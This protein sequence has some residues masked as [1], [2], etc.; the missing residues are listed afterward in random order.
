MVLACPKCDWRPQSY[1]QWTCTCGHRWHIFATD[2]VCPACGREWTSVR[3]F[4]YLGCGAWSDLLDWQH[5]GDQR[6]V[7]DF[8]AWEHHEH[9]K[10]QEA[11][12]P[13][14]CAEDTARDSTEERAHGSD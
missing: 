9:L 6:T 11:Q 8:L 5:D 7:E 2:G 14:D 10:E 4:T 12:L 13:C 1:H 3:C